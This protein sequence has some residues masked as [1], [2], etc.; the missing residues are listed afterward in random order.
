MTRL[1]LDVCCLNRPFDDQSQDRIRLEA[2]AVR[3]ILIRLHD[4]DWHWTS[5]EVVSLETEKTP[6]AKRRSRV[7]QIAQRAHN[8][9]RVRTAEEARGLDLERL[10][11]RVFDALHL[12]CAE[13][14]GVDVFLTT[15]DD[16]LRKA[17]RHKAALRV[18]VMNPLLWA[19][20]AGVL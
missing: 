3:V 6:D 11:F 19:R 1:Y 15:D 9:V 7:R 5:S 8:I 2:E 16:L 13:S 20:E 14:A 18:R 17:S 10:G 4:R 12:A